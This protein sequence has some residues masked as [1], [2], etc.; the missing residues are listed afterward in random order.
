M[1]VGVSGRIRR[2]CLVG[3]SIR[4]KEIEVPKII[5]MVQRRERHVVVHDIWDAVP[6]QNQ[7][8]APSDVDDQCDRDAWVDSERQNF[9][10]ANNVRRRRGLSRSK[11]LEDQL[12][13]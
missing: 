1:N 5:R 4:S 13:R 8:A 9:K 6:S 10:W 3:Q 11:L 12:H 2:Y 7:K